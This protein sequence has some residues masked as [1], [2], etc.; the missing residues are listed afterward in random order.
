[1]PVL[2]RQAATLTDWITA[3]LEQARLFSTANHGPP[4]AN[5]ARPLSLPMS[6]PRFPDQ[7]A[8]AR[9]PV[10]GPFGPNNPILL[11]VD[12]DRVW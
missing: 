12:D 4:I 2:A 10:G 7:G 5:R 9:G 11:I 3:G 8:H 1:M 6:S